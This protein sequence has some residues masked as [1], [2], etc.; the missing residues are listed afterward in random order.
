MREVRRRPADE[1]LVCLAAADPANL[2]GT[3]L[4]GPKVRARRRLAGAVSR[5]RADRHQR[6][7]RG[8]AACRGVGRRVAR[9]PRRAAPRADLEL[10]RPRSAGDAGLRSR[11]PA[12]GWP[13]GEKRPAESWRRHAKVINL[14]RTSTAED[15]R[16]HHGQPRLRAPRASALHRPSCR[17]VPAVGGGAAPS[18]GPAHCRRDHRAPR[19][20]LLRGGA[21]RPGAIFQSI[22][23]REPSKA[24]VLGFRGGAGTRRPRSSTARTRRATSRSST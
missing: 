8:R 17:A 9:D 14:R 11:S 10:A 22:E 18:D 15:R 6:R 5:R 23:L 12:A 16:E 1:T 19:N 3:V 24:D 7:R 2:L 21:A 13:A 20:I 4:P